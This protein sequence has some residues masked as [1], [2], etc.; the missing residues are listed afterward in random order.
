MIFQA[1]QPQDPTTFVTDMLLF[2]QNAGFAIYLLVKTPRGEKRQAS[3]VWI[4]TFLSIGIFAFCG[5][6][7]HWT[8]YV[9]VSD[10][11]WP[12]TMIF[13][14]LA[15]FFFN[16]GVLMHIFG[17]NSR[18]HLVLPGLFLV[19]YLIIIPILD[20]LFIL[21]VTYQLLCSI[22]IF[23]YAIPRQK[24]DP[25]LKSCVTGLIILL[26]A[27]VIQALGS[28][29][30]LKFLYGNAEQFIFKPHNDV[31]H[32]IAMIGLT[33]IFQGLRKNKLGIVA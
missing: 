20:W 24:A 28:M 32:I 18:K 1:L 12:P 7:S 26:V 27:G 31:F 25:F 16:V 2:L 21:F 17:K 10:V 3:I 6:I 14:G 30:G 29:L 4:C 8:K 11:M 33:I 23:L 9:A 5:A 15:F 19:I 13:G 22:M